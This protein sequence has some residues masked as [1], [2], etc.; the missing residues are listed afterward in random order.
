VCSVA[1]QNWGVA[2]A[3]FT[4]V[5]RDDNL[6]LEVL[7]VLG[8]VLLGVTAN[9]STANFL[10]GN[11]L[12][13]KANVVT[14]NGLFQ[15]FVV[16]FHGFDLGLNHG[17]GEDNLHACFQGTGLDTSNGNSPDT[18]DFVD[19]LE[20]KAQWLVGWALW[21]DNL[22]QGVDQAVTLVPWHVFGFFQHVVS[23]P[24]GDRD[25]G[26]LLWLVAN[27][28][29]EGKHIVLDFLEAGFLVGDGLVVHLVYANNHL[30]YTQGEGK[31]TVLAGLSVLGEGT[32]ETTLVTWDDKDGNIGLGGTGDHVLDKVTVSWGIDDGEVE[33]V[34][35]EFPQG[36]VDGDTTF[37]FG[38]EFV[39]N[40]GVLK[41]GFT[42]FT[43]F[44]LELFDGTLVDTPALVDQVTGGGG[45]T[46]ID[47]P[48]NN[49][50]T[51]KLCF[52]HVSCRSLF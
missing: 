14:W 2:G 49:Q 50:V 26:D 41:G 44:L 37:T 45:F 15:S 3:Y 18:A 35:F 8:R 19:I 46:G 11:V 38:L 27:G 47:V 48:D 43:G 13:V 28:L 29:Q 30:L 23:H 24:A 25:E 16:H 7:A 21:W 10:D 12:Y 33:L 22:V 9:V 32:F 31:K 52:T 51:V 20:W 1:I 36:N 17:W 39:Q 5:V 42:H 4:W 40:P 34:G 6:G